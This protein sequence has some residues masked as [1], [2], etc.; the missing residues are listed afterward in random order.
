LPT[1]DAVIDHQGLAD[2]APWVIGGGR[3]EVKGGAQPRLF[4]HPMH[5]WTDRE[6][7]ADYV[8]A[9]AGILGGDPVAARAIAVRIW[10]RTPSIAPPI[11]M[12]NQ[13][14]MVFSKLD[15]TPRWRERLS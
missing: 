11:Q 5:D 8:A 7:V 3:G 2:V 1:G 14:G 6:A 12:A 9:G 15:C 10:D 13:L 4:A